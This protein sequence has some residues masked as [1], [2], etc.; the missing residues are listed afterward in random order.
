MEIIQLNENEIA[1]IRPLWE[2][3]NRLHEEKSTYFKDHFA[4][5]TFDRRLAQFKNRDSVVVFA[6]R[7]TENAGNLVGYCIA[8]INNRIGEIDSIFILPG[9][10]STGIGNRLMT[11]AESCLQTQDVDKIQ[12]SVA[13]GNEAAFGF[14]NRHGYQ[15]RFSVLEKSV[16]YL[17]IDNG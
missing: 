7:D 12:I 1:D 17:R 15:H 5:F 16:N 6:A 13:Q 8:S 11:R 4:T 2:A 10:R 14:Y 3:L 9:L